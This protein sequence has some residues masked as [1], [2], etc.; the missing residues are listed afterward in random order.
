MTNNELMVAAVVSALFKCPFFGV[1]LVPPVRFGILLGI[2]IWRRG[3]TS[4]SSI[5]VFACVCV[6]NLPSAL[7]LPVSSFL[8]ENQVDYVTSTLASAC[9]SKE[10]RLASKVV[11][12]VLK[13]FSR[14]IST[15]VKWYVGVAIFGIF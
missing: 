13:S 6:E 12:T 14:A 5:R 7:P 4:S 3:P 1:L 2:W 8:L 10:L 11:S 9:L 15:P